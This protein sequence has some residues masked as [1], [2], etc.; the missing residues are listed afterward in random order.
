M[1]DAAPA[2]SAARSS[3]WPLVTVAT[4][5]LV[6]GA[7]TMTLIGGPPGARPGPPAAA[8]P[9]ADAKPG[10]PARRATPASPSSGSSSG[11]KWVGSRQPR[12]ASDGSRTIAFELAADN[13]V[14]VWMKRVRPVLAVRCLSETTDV[15]VITGSAAS[16]EGNASR[17]TVRVSFDEGPDVEAH[18]LDSVDYQALFAPDGEV[19]ARQI[20]GARQMRFGFTPYNASPVV[21]DFDVSGFDELIESV[22][23]TCKWKTDHTVSK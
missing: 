5:A 18:W 2:G 1:K 10:G 12:W 14:P 22:A 19:V 13:Y 17:H 4:A 21:A 7:V 20:A 6:I 23:K 15:F 8:G 11:A 16:I 9:S 3:T